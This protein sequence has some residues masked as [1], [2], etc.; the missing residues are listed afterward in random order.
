M[1]NTKIPVLF[2]EFKHLAL[3]YASKNKVSHKSA[4]SA[5][6][7][8][9][10]VYDKITDV[11][12]HILEND[13]NICLKGIP[14]G[15]RAAKILYDKITEHDRTNY[16][17]N[18]VRQSFGLPPLQYEPRDQEDFTALH[19]LD[20]LDGMMQSKK[21]DFKFQETA[22][23]TIKQQNQYFDKIV[24]EGQEDRTLQFAEKAK[25][26]GQQRQY[27]AKDIS[28]FNDGQL[29]AELGLDVPKK[30]S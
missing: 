5:L 20:M 13:I 8:N 1:K 26:E 2:D 22:K 24:K 11:N 19:H 23:N 30:A 16:H 4:V 10:Q 25:A 9:Y 6:G 7:L 12:R 15:E 14:N 29:R 28:V 21:S 3:D 17:V 27:E 18:K